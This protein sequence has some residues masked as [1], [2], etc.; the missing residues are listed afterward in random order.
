MNFFIG[1]ASEIYALAGDLA[2]VGAKAVPA[3]RAGMQSA[4]E[5]F[6][7]TWASNARA[8]SGE[9]GVHYPASITAELVFD[10]G[11]VSVDVGPESGRPQGGMSFE[12]GSQNQPPHLDGLRALG[13][14]DTKLTR[15]SDDALR[16]IVP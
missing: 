3:V 8:T 2:E 14:A 1:D 16:G 9:H 12:F 13:P 5:M 11:G 6:A 15:L 10:L 4:G 7:E